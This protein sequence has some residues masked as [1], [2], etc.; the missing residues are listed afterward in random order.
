M[1]N[2]SYQTRGVCAREIS[3]SIQDGKLY[4]VHFNGGCPGNTSAI[5]KLLEGTDAMRAV[6]ILRGND[7]GGRGTSCADQLAIGLEQALASHQQ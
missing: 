7:C 3:F 6:E 2:Y 4:N 5:S 1:E